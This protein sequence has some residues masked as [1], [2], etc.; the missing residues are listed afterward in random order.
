MKDFLLRIKNIKIDRDI[1]LFALALTVLVF[2]IFRF[3]ISSI[4]YNSIITLTFTHNWEGKEDVLKNIIREFEELHNEEIKIKLNYM[5]YNNISMAAPDGIL[6]GDIIALDS[7]MIPEFIG[8]ELIEPETLTLL[9][10]IHPL[11]YNI[12]ILAGNGFIRPP[13]TRSEFLIQ[14]RTIAA[15]EDGIY[16]IAMALSQDNPRSHLRDL[17][18]WALASGTAITENEIREL[19]NFVTILESER[20]LLPGV[21]LMEEHEKRDAFINGKTAFMIGTAEDMDFLR[22]SL[23]ESLDYTAIPVPDNYIGRPVFV[24]GS[25]NLGIA[26]ESRHR[27]EALLFSEFLLEQVSH[28]ADDWAIHGSGN[29]STTS[30]PFYSKL[31]EL[32]ISGD[33]IDDFEGIS[34]EQ[35]RLDIIRNL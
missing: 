7:F 12:D 3:W 26:R 10:F 29:I 14:A 11:Y 6:T 9:T 30:D 1:L 21:F 23:G 20:L 25:W 16:A 31:R 19:I 27:E 13:R 24:A 33:L 5:P 18:S 4:S 15:E 2:S 28:L 8:D 35:I 32:Y 17:F 34:F 22:Q